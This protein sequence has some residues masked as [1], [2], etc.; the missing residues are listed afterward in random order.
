[1]IKG[2]VG[3]PHTRTSGMEGRLK[4][5]SVATQSIVIGDC[6]GESD[7]ENDGESDGKDSGQ[8]RRIHKCSVS[9]KEAIWTQ[10]S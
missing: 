5:R 6:H 8:L 2:G 10:K 1:M 9:K 7:G 3:Q 4:H